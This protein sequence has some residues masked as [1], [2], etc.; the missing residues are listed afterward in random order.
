M[1]TEIKR[2][3]SKEVATLKAVSEETFYDT[4]SADNQPENLQAYLTSAYQTEKLMAELENPESFFYFLFVE[5]QL[6]GYLK[7]N[8]DKAQTENMGDSTLEIERIYIRKDFKQQGL[9]TL[10]M[11]KAIEEAIKL[12]K[13]KLWLGVW[14]KNQPAIAFYQKMGFEKFGSHTFYLGNE[15]QTDELMQKEIVKP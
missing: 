5:K 1:E 9:G 7:L 3:S 13:T 12:N 8:I 10:L 14:E 11:Q 2:I 15:K 4:F 6:A